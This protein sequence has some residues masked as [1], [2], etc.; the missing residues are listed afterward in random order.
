MKS[1]AFHAHAEFEILDAELLGHTAG[2]VE[3]ELAF[4]GDYEVNNGCV[5]DNY[6]YQCVSPNAFCGVNSVCA[7]VL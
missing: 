2:G 3:F 6:N 5:K 4:N 7:E 1:I